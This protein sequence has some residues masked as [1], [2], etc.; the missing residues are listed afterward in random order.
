MTRMPD[1]RLGID[2]AEPGG[3]WTAIQLRQGDIVLGEIRLQPGQEPLIVLQTSAC[4]L[5][6]VRPAAGVNVIQVFNCVGQLLGQLHL[7]DNT[8][9]PY[10]ENP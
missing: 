8:Y 3:S 2:L 6:L 4:N 1:P 7:S 5:K 10:Q 9:H